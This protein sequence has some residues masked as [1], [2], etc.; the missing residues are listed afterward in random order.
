MVCEKINLILVVSLDQQYS[1]LRFVKNVLF[2]EPLDF[3]LTRILP[4]ATIFQYANS[5]DS[6]ETPSNSASHP[7]ISCLTLGLPFH[8]LRTTLKHLIQTR[9]VADDIVHGRIKVE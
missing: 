1:V 4:I 8:N 3:H 9:Y 7:D 2:S 5:L 6:N